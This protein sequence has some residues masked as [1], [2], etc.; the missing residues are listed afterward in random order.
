[1]SNLLS[2]VEPELAIHLAINVSDIQRSVDFYKILF[3][4][5]PAKFYGD[6]AKFELENP[7]LVFS[8]LP[9][10]DDGQPVFGGSMS[11]MG[12]RLT[13]EQE[14]QE[15]KQRFNRFGI[16]TRSQERVNGCYA[17]QSKIWVND[18]DCNPWEIY[19]VYEDLPGGGQCVFGSLASDCKKVE[20]TP[21]KAIFRGP[22]P[23]IVIDGVGAFERGKPVSLSPQ[24]LEC[25][26]LHKELGS[27]IL[28]PMNSGDQS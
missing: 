4:R 17:V 19:V 18:P 11:H 6:Y 2:V 21:H 20:S 25:L 10:L 3:D 12:F 24:Q 14:V 13:S 27:F 5:E 1:M 23:Q 26:Q 8:L 15:V 28:T 16:E 22:D 9:K 7:R